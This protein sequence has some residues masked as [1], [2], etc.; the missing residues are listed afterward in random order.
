MPE[1]EAL[2]ARFGEIGVQVLGLSV[3][4]LHCHA[5]WGRDLGGVSFPLLA[6]FQP[7][8]E[9]GRAFGAYLDG[10]GLDD[11]ATVIITRDGIVRH[12]SSVGPGGRR[13]MDELLE[14]ARAIAEAHPGAEPVPAGTPVS[15]DA[16]TLYVKSSCG[17]SRRVLTALENLHARDAVTIKNV[18]DDADAAKALE[19]ASKQDKAPCLVLD[20][21]AI[22]ESATILTRLADRLAP[23]AGA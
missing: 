15:A 1:L 16:A 3:D 10:P 2:R 18:T 20:G 23:V 5:A 17:P 19:A 7:K 12:A 13:N 4:S 8:G 21:D 6:D 11:R 22:V 14:T 9:V